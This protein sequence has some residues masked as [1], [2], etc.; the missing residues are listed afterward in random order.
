MKRDNIKELD[1]KKQI[2]SIVDKSYHAR[3]SFHSFLKKK[4]TRNLRLELVPLGFVS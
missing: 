3:L 4:V 1:K 2:K